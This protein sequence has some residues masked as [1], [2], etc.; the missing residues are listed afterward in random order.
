MS[1]KHDHDESFIK[2]LTKMMGQFDPSGKEQDHRNAAMNVA[3][4]L[5]GRIDK[6]NINDPT[7]RML[8][9]LSCKSELHLG[10]K[11]SSEFNYTKL[12]DDSVKFD[13]NDKEQL[14]K[15]LK[16][17]LK[18]L[19]KKLI[20]DQFKNEKKENTFDEN[21]FEKEFEKKMKE[22]ASNPSESGKLKGLAKLS[23]LLK[24]MLE[25]PKPKQAKNEQKSV[26]DHGQKAR[27]QD[28]AMRYGGNVIRETGRVQYVVLGQVGNLMGFLDYDASP[29]NTFQ[30]SVDSPFS[31]ACDA[32]GTH[33]ASMAKNL[34]SSP[35]DTPDEAK[36][37]E[38]ITGKKQ[39]DSPKL[40]M[41][42]DPKK[43]F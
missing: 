31:G 17:E 16:L 33:A 30:G 2:E 7:T 34:S 35:I 28:E 37:E 41:G 20:K 13:K 3:K 23:L 38:K 8:L 40:T 12:F 22:L 21:K 19:L 42:K 43:P 5:G 25:G 24:K 36:A 4:K 26:D 32:L 9:V 1:Y 39:N 15:E 11:Q 10:K 27:D 18:E 6:M 29:S 14:N